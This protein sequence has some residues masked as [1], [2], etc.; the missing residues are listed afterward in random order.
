VFV[1]VD[2]SDAVAR[3]WGIG[4]QRPPWPARPRE[5]D[6]AD[7]SVPHFKS[8]RRWEANSHRPAC[9]RPPEQQ[10]PK[11]T[12]YREAGLSVED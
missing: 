6:G 12:P 8:A 11:M 10:S 2:A 1:V 9:G 3:R 4:Q 7:S 5:A